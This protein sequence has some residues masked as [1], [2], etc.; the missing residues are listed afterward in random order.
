MTD[1][2]SHHRLRWCTLGL[3]RRLTGPWVLRFACSDTECWN[4]QYLNF[5]VWRNQRGVGVCVVRTSS[6]VQ[7]RQRFQQRARGW[8]ESPGRWW[9]SDSR[10]LKRTQES[11]FRDA[12]NS[13]DGYEYSHNKNNNN[14]HHRFFNKWQIVFFVFFWLHVSMLN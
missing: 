13:H 2:D 5:R 8:A 7:N 3:M 12:L 4:N 10:R 9:S 14:H 1:I 6:W 11:E